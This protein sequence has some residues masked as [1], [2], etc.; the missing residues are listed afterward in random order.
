M[1]FVVP[2]G[3]RSEHCSGHL[4]GGASETSSVPSAQ[5]LPLPL[6]LLLLLVELVLPPAPPSPTP[7]VMAAPQSFAY[8]FLEGGPSVQIRQSRGY[9]PLPSKYQQ[10]FAPARARHASRHADSDPW[11]PRDVACEHL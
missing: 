8:V 4:A 9:P 6:L 7:H 3:S 2:I 5:P 11:S 10:P 1:P